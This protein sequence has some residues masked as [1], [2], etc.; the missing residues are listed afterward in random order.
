M[1]RRTYVLVHRR[2]YNTQKATNTD[3]FIAQNTN[4]RK[5]AISK[6]LRIH[7]K[8]WR[9]N[10]YCDVSVRRHAGPTH[11]TH[12][13]THDASSWI[14]FSRTAR[15]HKKLKFFVRRHVLPRRTCRRTVSPKTSEIDRRCRVFRICCTYTCTVRNRPIVN[16][17]AVD[18]D[19]A[20][21]EL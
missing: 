8:L 20:L 2:M 1:I 12:H 13:C 4:A 19:C 6:H 5:C 9:L 16:T 18:L 11:C 14:R 7:N 10:D 15:I 3:K 21:N 17:D